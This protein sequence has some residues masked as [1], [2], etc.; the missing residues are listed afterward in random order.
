MSEAIGW[1]ELVPER[2][3]GGM[4]A[5]IE[6]TKA[7]TGEYPPE[8]PGVAWLVKTMAGWRCE[9]CGHEHTPTPP[10]VLTVHHLIPVKWNL[11]HWNLA[12]LCQRCHLQIQHRVQFLQPWPFEHTPWMARHVADYNEWA[13]RNGELLLPLNGLR[14]ALDHRTYWPAREALAP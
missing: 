13:E 3:H 10:W 12:A 2:L 4:A 9:R 14:E 6:A 7:K 11:Q 8:W 1:P 5:T